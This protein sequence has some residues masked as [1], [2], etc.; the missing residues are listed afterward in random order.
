MKILICLLLLCSSFITAIA[1]QDGKFTIN[2]PQDWKPETIPFPLGFAPEIPYQGFEE[3][4]F[5]PGMFKRES[6][7]YFSYFFFWSLQGK[8]EIGKETLARD[9]TKY[10]QGLCREVG[11]GRNLTLDLT[12]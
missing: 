10:F 3:L 8:P 2:A 6:A 4:R 1:G 12:K 5:A 11:K 7:S 9:L